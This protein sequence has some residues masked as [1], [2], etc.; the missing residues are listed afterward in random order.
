MQDHHFYTLPL[1]FFIQSATGS[2]YEE[3]RRL[4]I[5]TVRRRLWKE[6]EMSWLVYIHVIMSCKLRVDVRQT[7]GNQAKLWHKQ[8]YFIQFCDAMHMM[9]YR[10]YGTYQYCMQPAD[11]VLTIHWF[12]CNFLLNSFYNQEVAMKR[13]EVCT[14][15][16]CEEDFEGKVLQRWDELTHVHTWNHVM[17]A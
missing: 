7:H 8:Q 16:Q 1:E 17:E 2:S 11:V 3:D 13:T 6:G 4:Y 5:L 15:W 10:L 14:S 12:W 9:S